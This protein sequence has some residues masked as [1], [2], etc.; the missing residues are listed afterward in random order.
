MPK[1]TKDKNLG[2]DTS[3]AKIAKELG[4]DRNKISWALKDDPRVPEDERQRIK[5]HVA[6]TG[7]VATFHP[8]Q[9]HNDKLTQ[10]RADLVVD[11]IFK[12][13][14]LA[15]IA[16]E[17]GLANGT[18]FKLIRGVKVPADYPETEDA[19]RND[20]IS[21]MEIAIWK[22]TKRLA[23]NGMDEIDARTVP[24]ATAILTDKLGI[25]KGQPTSIHATLSLTANHR[26]LM[27]ELG[28]KNGTQAADVETNAE[29]M[30]EGA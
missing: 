7:Y 19:W 9:H 1:P 26:D 2:K 28:A 23:I 25:M 10:E 18:A 6:Q 4:V 17:T 16:A 12:N 27:K 21:F 8:D 30:P 29:V 22:G 3:L 5:D 14:P 13:T 15:T 24:I 20:V 11:G